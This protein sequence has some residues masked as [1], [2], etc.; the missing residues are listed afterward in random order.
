[1]TAHRVECGVC[2][3]TS[4]SSPSGQIP[5]GWALECDRCSK[6]TPARPKKSVRHC[7]LCQEPI[8]VMGVSG[9]VRLLCR[10]CAKK[11]ANLVDVEKLVKERNSLLLKVN[12][13]MENTTTE[14]AQLEKLKEEFQTR[15]HHKTREIREENDSLKLEL[16]RK[17]ETTLSDRIKAKVKLQYGQTRRGLL[18]DFLEWYETNGVEERGKSAVLDRYFDYVGGEQ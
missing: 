11:D 16:Q 14:R 18:E 10:V 5:Q 12:D 1:M 13:L 3:Q 17:T 7:S 15:L 8:I 9:G 2:H 6:G 4:Y